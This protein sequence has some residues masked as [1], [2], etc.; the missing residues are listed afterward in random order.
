MSILMKVTVVEDL[1]ILCDI[2]EGESS[3]RISTYYPNDMKYAE[4]LEDFAV[5]EAEIHM[6]PTV[7]YGY[8]DTGGSPGLV[9]IDN[10]EYA[11]LSV[12]HQLKTIVM[13]HYYE[14]V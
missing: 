4:D 10:R 3:L 12:A 6:P 8:T 13:A 14:E 11:Y 2:R 9:E 7:A 5:S 1:S